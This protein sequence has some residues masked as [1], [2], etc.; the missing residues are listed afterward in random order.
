MRSASRVDFD[1][2][3]STEPQSSRLCHRE[4][5]GQARRPARRI[6]WA[7]A[8]LCVTGFVFIGWGLQ[9]AAMA[10]VAYVGVRF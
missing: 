8:G 4:Q 9:A 5:D 6:L 2:R 10:A 3:L 1:V 7:I